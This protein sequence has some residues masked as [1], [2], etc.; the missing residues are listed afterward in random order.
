VW[1][2]FW[3]LL[4]DKPTM[5]RGV[6][7]SE[8]ALI[9]SDPPDEV[10]SVP[11]ARLF[12]KRGTWSYGL[13][14]FLTDPVWWFFLFWLPKYL[15]E[16]FNLP[17]SGI[18]LPTIVV[19]NISTIGSVGGGWISS[20]LIKRGW[21]VNSARKTAMLIC[22]L[23]VVPVLYAPFCKNLWGVVALVGVAM[24][25]HQGWSAN[26]YTIVSDVF[27]RSA[28]GSVVGIGG[29][30][31]AAGGVL[32]QLVA[33]KVVHAGETLQNGKL[34]VK[35]LTYL[36]LFLFAGIAYVAALAIIQR[37]TPKLAA[38]AVES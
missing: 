4:Y 36:P 2:V 30:M 9:Q 28:V 33:G 1:I 5:R 29:A 6:S 27:P 37:L 20:G 21:S 26:L 22:A 17:L 31:G 32:M 25:A 18:V 12:P 34:V 13:G 24:A 15:Q 19:Y 10:A 16:T 8:L 7:A 3:L 11:W 38:E 14:K 23:C 35:D